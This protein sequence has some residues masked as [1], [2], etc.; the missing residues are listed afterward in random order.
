VQ[1]LKWSNNLQRQDFHLA[2]G[3]AS[4]RFDH[5]IRIRYSSPTDETRADAPKPGVTIAFAATPA[6]PGV[7]VASN[8]G[9]VRVA[10]SLP[11]LPAGTTWPQMLTVTCTATEGGIVKGTANVNVWV[12]QARQADSARERGASAL[13]SAGRVH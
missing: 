6:V 13:F 3:Y 7:T 11:A 1:S 12:H 9:E 5:L 2:P 8:T 4:P 10:S